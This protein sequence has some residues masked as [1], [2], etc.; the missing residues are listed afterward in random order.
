M[1]CDYRPLK[2]VPY[3]VCLTVGGDKL[4]YNDDAKSPAASLIKTKL[5]LNSIIFQATQGV[6][7]MALDII[8]FFSKLS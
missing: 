6:Q 1:V 2:S 7:F 3:R 5:N 4:P 8:D